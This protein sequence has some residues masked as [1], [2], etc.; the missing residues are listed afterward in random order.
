MLNHPMTKSKPWT[1]EQTTYKPKAGMMV[2]FPSWLWHGVEP[3]MND[4]PRISI[5]F[6]IGYKKV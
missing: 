3:N 1:A 6:N 2:I 5:A 4:K